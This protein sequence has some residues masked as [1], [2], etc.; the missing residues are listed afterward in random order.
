MAPPLGPVSND[1]LYSGLRD[2]LLFSKLFLH[3]LLLLSSIQ[4]LLPTLVNFMADSSPV[5]LL[6]YGFLTK[7]QH[8]DTHLHS[9]SVQNLLLGGLWSQLLHQSAF[10]RPDKAISLKRPPLSIA[11]MNSTLHCASV[12]GLYIVALP[13]F[14][15]VDLWIWN[16]PSHFRD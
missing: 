11:S 16:D 14:I 6:W 5:C 1:L 2:A 10:H 7:F 9:I 15:S 3:L 4:K 8:P 13:C 12:Q